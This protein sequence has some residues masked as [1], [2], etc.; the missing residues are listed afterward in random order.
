MGST[1]RK[2]LNTLAR[3]F[4]FLKNSLARI[5]MMQIEQPDSK[6]MP[7]DSPAVKFRKINKDTFA[8]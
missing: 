5:R 1:T 8:N 2:G 4:I 6:T 3:N 7:H